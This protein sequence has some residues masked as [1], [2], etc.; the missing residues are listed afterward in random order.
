[1]L[2]QSIFIALT[3]RGLTFKMTKRFVFGLMI[4]PISLLLWDILVTR[5]NLLNIHNLLQL[6]FS[7]LQLI[8]NHLNILQQFTDA[9]FK[10]PHYQSIRPNKN[11]ANL[12]LQYISESRLSLNLSR[13]NEIL[14]RIS[15]LDD[16]NFD[17]SLHS[18]MVPTPVPIAPTSLL[19]TPNT[20]SAS[21]NN[22]TRKNTRKGGAA[23]SAFKLPT[24]YNSND[25]EQL[26]DKET[27]QTNAGLTESS[28]AGLT[29]SSSA[30]LTESSSDS[31]VVSSASEVVSSDSS[32]ATKASNNTSK[33]SS[34][35]KK[36]SDDQDLQN[37]RR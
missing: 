18:S 36:A 10:D 19:P 23:L 25:H 1:M 32:G 17:P 14:T 2:Q 30:G 35:R 12:I 11:E 34:K 16:S 22:K 3:A 24:R 6:L 15:T 33:K 8:K 26:S 13:T 28:S 5:I 31:I 21:Q 7:I 29:E 27:G 4:L 20:V 9:R 37:P